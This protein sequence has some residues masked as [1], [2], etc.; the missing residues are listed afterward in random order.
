MPSAASSSA[1][2]A[3]FMYLLPNICTNWSKNL[4]SCFSPLEAKFQSLFKSDRS[5]CHECMRTNAVA[6]M[7]RGLNA[8]CNEWRLL[9]FSLRG[10]VGNWPSASLSCSDTVQEC[11]GNPG[12]PWPQR[13]ES[14]CICSWWSPSRSPGCPRSSIFLGGPRSRCRSTPALNSQSPTGHLRQPTEWRS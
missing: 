9:T 10:S 7:L 1:G 8:W 4:H 14:R 3:F 2:S 5:L 6:H 12:R 11:A 13:S